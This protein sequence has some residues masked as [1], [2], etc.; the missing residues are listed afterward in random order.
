[1][2]T[3]HHPKGNGLRYL[4]VV[5]GL[6]F[7]LSVSVWVVVT[8]ASDAMSGSGQVTHRAASH[9]PAAGSAHG[10]P[11]AERAPAPKQSSGQSATSTRAPVRR[12][13]YRDACPDTAMACVD[14][15]DKVTWLQKGGVVFYGP[16]PM[17]AGSPG[18]ETPTGLFQVQYKI[19]H[20]IS[21]EFNEPMPNSVFF[22]PGGIAFHEGSLTK[23]SHG[24]VHLTWR[25]SA[26]YFD[27]LPVGAQVAVF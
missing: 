24:C 16:V 20:H 21:N 13:K 19:K 25:D 18:Q 17:E 7:A 11:A 22:A 5:A 12:W 1:M 2:P 23:G 10:S 3:R 8:P 4:A 26:Y 9:R 6:A 15:K 14:L 27:N